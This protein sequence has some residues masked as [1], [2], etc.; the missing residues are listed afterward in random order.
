MQTNSIVVHLL[1]K[2]SLLV[3]G[4]WAFL[5][6]SAL[7]YHPFKWHSPTLEFD[8]LHSNNVTLNGNDPRKIAYSTALHKSVDNRDRDMLI[9]KHREELREMACVHWF[10]FIFCIDYG[11]G[12]WDMQ[13]TSGA[14]GTVRC[15][16]LQAIPLNTLTYFL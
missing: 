11:W 15:K 8:L 16:P 5:E 6:Y 10:H 12:E 2:D 1:F 14:T 3:C 13:H 4:L 7:L 9:N